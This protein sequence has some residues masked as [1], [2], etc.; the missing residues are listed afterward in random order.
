MSVN[1]SLSRRVVPSLLLFSTL[2]VA[3]AA[4]GGG[5]RRRLRDQPRAD[6]GAWRQD[7]YPHLGTFVEEA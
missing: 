5:G 4:C 2:A 6:L 3:L 7:D 1:E